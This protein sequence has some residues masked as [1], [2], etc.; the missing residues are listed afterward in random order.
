MSEFFAFLNVTKYIYTKVALTL[1]LAL[2]VHSLQCVPAMGSPTWFS[3]RVRITLELGKPYFYSAVSRW[4]V[5]FGE[6]GLRHLVSSISSG[7]GE[8]VGMRD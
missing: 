5:V 2:S 6:H 8:R 1:H 7:K 3:M 4:Q